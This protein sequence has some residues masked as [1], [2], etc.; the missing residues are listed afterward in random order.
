MQTMRA[1]VEE[2]NQED[3][4]FKELE[5]ITTTSS[6]NYK[7]DATYEEYKSMH[8]DVPKC[9]RNF[10][11]TLI[12]FQMVGLQIFKRNQSQLLK[13]QAQ[14]KGQEEMERALEVSLTKKNVLQK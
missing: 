5:A 14:V 11:R 9:E 13:L 8:T 12:H 4:A 10:L 3:N 1:K 2:Q 6:H 7:D